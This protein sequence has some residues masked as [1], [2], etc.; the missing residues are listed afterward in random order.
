M[1]LISTNI[2]V[3]YKNTAMFKL[4]MVNINQYLSGLY[5]Y[6]FVQIIDG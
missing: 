3:S 4:L 5:K 1:L 6:W 2:P